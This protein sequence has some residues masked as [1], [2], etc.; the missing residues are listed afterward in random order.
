MDAPKSPDNMSLQFKTDCLIGFGM[1][2]LASFRSIIELW[3]SREAMAADIEAK[4]AAVSK[5]WQRDSVPAEWWSS[6]LAT[7]IAVD[8]GLNAEALTA[9]AARKSEVADLDEARA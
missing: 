1:T 9:L 8:A 5:W 4:A 7:G 6:L 3:P 2:D